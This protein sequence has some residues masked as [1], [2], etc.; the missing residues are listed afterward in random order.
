MDIVR[1][2]RNEILKAKEH[3]D[4]YGFVII[5]DAFDNQLLD[6]FKKEF[7]LIIRAY[8]KKAGIIEEIPFDQLFHKGMELL[9]A[10]DRTY[11]GAVYDT[12]SLSPP[13]L[14]I[15]SNYLTE[16]LVRVL[17]GDP[18]APLYGFTNRCLF[19]PPTDERRTYGWH[20]EVFYTVPRG[21]YIQTWAPLIS[22]SSI[23]N[24][25]IEIA[26]CS[27]KEGIAKQQWN[28]VAGRTTQI[29][30]DDMIMDKY[31]K[32]A[33]EMELGELLLFSGFLAHRSGTNT[34]NQHR[35]SLVGM[36][37]DVSN[38]E[39]ITPS[40]RFNFR[41]ETP[42]EFYEKSFPESSK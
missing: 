21:K 31:E 17:L 15:I 32:C 11:I 25:T 41:G 14:R 16:Q 22:G 8:L 37:H 4:D 20:Q 27:H 42:R 40:L 13:F 34:S 19:A 5:K 2:Y 30:I 10:K 9:E 1:F 3:F 35:Y 29:I 39:F 7:A 23:L 36:Y 6:G 38:K 24:G 12:I 33:V 28:E 26:P 18:N